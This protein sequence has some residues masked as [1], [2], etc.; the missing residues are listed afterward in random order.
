LGIF[1]KSTTAVLAAMVMTTIAQKG[2]S[3]PW[4]WRRESSRNREPEMGSEAEEN[5]ERIQAEEHQE[6]ERDLA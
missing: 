6:R 5:G 2:A 3:C 4:S 1:K